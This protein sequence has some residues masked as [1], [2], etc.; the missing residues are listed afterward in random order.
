MPFFLSTTMWNRRFVGAFAHLRKAEISFIM[1][2]RPSAWKKSGPAGRTSKKFQIWVFFENLYKEFKFHWD[3]TRLARNLHEDLSTIVLS[4]RVLIWMRYVSDK[5]CGQN[6][7]T[8]FVF[9][10][11]SLENRAVYEMMWKNILELGRP[12]M[13]IWRTDSACSLDT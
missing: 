3:V 13:T 5:S 11:V 6:Q 4:P 2:V 10:N 12:Q 1:S 7:N 8:Y 9:S